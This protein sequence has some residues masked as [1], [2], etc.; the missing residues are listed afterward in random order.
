MKL[1]KHAAHAAL[2]ASL[3]WSGSCSQEDPFNSTTTTGPVSVAI[4]DAASNDI[5]VFEVDVTG[6]QLK[7]VSGATVSVLSTTARVD[8]A[9]L[10]DTSN[11]LA[12]SRV[13][14]GAYTSATITLDLSNARCLLVGKTTTATLRDAN[15]VALTGT[16]TVPLQLGSPFTVASTAHRLLELDFDIDQSFVVD[17]VGNSV[18]LEPAFVLRVDPTLPRQI[19]AVG[20]LT[21]VDTVGSTFL[22]NVRALGG[23]VISTV[24]FQ[25]S[26]ATVFQIDGV[27]STGS[28]GLTALS[29]L[30]VDAPIQCFG[31]V[32]PTTARFN[33]LYVEAGVGTY[34]GG[35]D[36]IEGHIVG[37]T[38]GAG[39]DAVF[40]VLG[41]SSNPAHTTF[42]Y[43]TTFLVN[44]SFT[45]THVVRRGSASAFDVDDLSV[46][47][48]VRVFGTLSGTT[49]SANTTT[50]VIR[51]QPT[52]VFGPAAG[53]P[54]GTTLTLDL[55][56][57]D[58]LADTVFDWADGG[59]TPVDPNAL[60]AN[61][62][63]L[64]VG[65]GINSTSSVTAIGYFSGISDSGPDFT[66]TAL[67]NQSTAASLLF[68]RNRPG[69]GLNVL[70]TANASQIQLNVSGVAATGEV[71]I[72]DRGFLGSIPLPTA[73][74]PT[75][76]HPAVNGF[77]SL[78]DRTNQTVRI[79]TRFSDF[80]S[81][82][83]SDIV[84]GATLVQLGAVGAYTQGINTLDATVA[85]AVVE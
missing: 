30:P 5:V 45:D 42:L 78:R 59:F 83:Q 68:V 54:A 21:S 84:Q 3:L 26:G 11:L 12:S 35:T 1:L 22:G 69:L 82:L 62:G 25:A 49:M 2:C 39:S 13:P 20:T 43:A 32:A 47:Q 81:A 67:V 76:T 33:V 36:V 58:L 8:L 31:S 55:A 60:V 41:F 63:A 46:G 64:G 29:G 51:M 85:A 56:R 77:Y 75:V 19:V 40:E 37:R 24:L 18:A 48:L 16:I 65:L 61:V 72:V 10:V 79:F 9:S 7:R 50:S 28:A 53:A 44:T 80:S 66:A 14:I 71:A 73:P 23:S 15:G 34:N 70:T 27:P 52:R 57:V 74:T 4:T 38:G 6:I 17:M